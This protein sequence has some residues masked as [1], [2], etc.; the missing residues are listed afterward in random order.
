MNYYLVD[1]PGRTDDP[2]AVARRMESHLRVLYHSDDV[3][4][5]A[6]VPW[7]K[8]MAKVEALLQDVAFP[9]SGDAR[10]DAMHNLH[11]AFVECGGSL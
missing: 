6:D 5:R 2:E 9:T 10:M 1:L 4:V 8:L 3:R 7:H 11:L